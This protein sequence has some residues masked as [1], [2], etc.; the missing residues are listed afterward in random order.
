MDM[1]L[2]HNNSA[3]PLRTLY[4]SYIK[5]SKWITKGLG[6]SCKRMRLL[7]VLRKQWYDFSREIQDHVNRYQIKLKEEKLIGMFKG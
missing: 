5:N 3:F 4:R 1:I 7:N 2:Y 6:N